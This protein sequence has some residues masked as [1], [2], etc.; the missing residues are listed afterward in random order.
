MSFE[1]ENLLARPR[2]LHTFAVRSSLPVI[3]LRPLGEN[4]TAVMLAG[5]LHRADYRRLGAGKVPDDR[6][7][8]VAARDRPVAL[9]EKRPQAHTGRMAVE[10]IGPPGF[11]F[12]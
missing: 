6:A 12:M 10:L 2:S 5:A 3:A 8:V 11:G 1:G 9:A 4:T 7:V